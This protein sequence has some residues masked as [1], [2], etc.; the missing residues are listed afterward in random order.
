MGIEVDGR[1]VRKAGRN[2]PFNNRYL[3]RAGVAQR[4]RHRT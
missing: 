4:Q 3:Q 2:A 1:L